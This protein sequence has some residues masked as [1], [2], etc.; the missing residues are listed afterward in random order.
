MKKVSIWLLV[1]ALVF[2]AACNPTVSP[3]PP[4]GD[5]TTTD[6][7]VTT[8][9][10]VAQPAAKPKYDAVGTGMEKP[11]N[12]VPDVI[13]YRV[14]IPYGE[15]VTGLLNTA[16]QDEINAFIAEHETET[17]L[18]QVDVVNGYM[19]VEVGGA[20]VLYDLYEGKRIQF[21]D[22]F[23]KDVAFVPTLNRCIQKAIQQAVVYAE[24]A[25]PY[26]SE[27]N[28][29]AFT[30]LKADH[31]T[32]YLDRVFLPNGAYH[33]GQDIY[34]TVEG[35]HNDSVLSIA[36]DMQGVFEA[37]KI[38]RCFSA[39]PAHTVNHRLENTNDVLGLLDVT[40]YPDCPVEKINAAILDI[41]EKYVSIDAMNAWHLRVKGYD[42]PHKQSM[43]Y[44]YTGCREIGDRYFEF[45]IDR[46]IGSMGD[47]AYG[48]FAYFDRETGEEVPYDHFLK[49]GW[50]SAA[51]W[52]DSSFDGCYYFGLREEESRLS[53]PPDIEGAMPMYFIQTN[54]EYLLNLALPNGDVPLVT[55]VI[56]FD[57]VDWSL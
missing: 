5:T 48:V 40:R 12:F 30:G 1:S 41:C 28:P 11:K 27:I 55:A 32:F 17:Y 3:A 57:Y 19:S 18:S 37:E 35:L 15:K 56:P 6:T 49:D 24:D 52:Y 46:N 38:E 51:A 44:G 20:I 34:A 42:H 31:T 21:S 25:A 22:L 2:L 4:S 54:G 7:T 13:S 8:T 39:Y 23:F 14:T 43:G 29:E 33:I 10:T 9:T 53:A 45:S 47:L 36:R 16:L 50:E 26:G